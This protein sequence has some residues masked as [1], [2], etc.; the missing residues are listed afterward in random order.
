MP[1]FS[2]EQ[3]YADSGKARFKEL[4]DPWNTDSLVTLEKEK[5][6]KVSL[7]KIYLS[8][9]E[10]DP[11][12]VTFADEVFGDLGFWLRLKE[13]LMLKSYFIEW[14]NIA[15]ERRKRM[16]FKAIIDEVKNNG[17][18]SFTAAKYLVEEP[19]KT[20]VS[21]ARRKQIKKD[22]EDTAHKAFVSSGVAEDWER[23]QSQDNLN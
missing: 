21:A 22:I 19:W 8:L 1:L 11:S 12:E 14:A 7:Y 15:S 10:D 16:A 3:L 18:S 20:S 9:V 23:I 6:G 13:S 5:E 17:K 2:K 4:F